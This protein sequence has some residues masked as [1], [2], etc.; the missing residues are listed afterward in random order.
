MNAK[1]GRFLGL[2]IVTAFALTVAITV[3]AGGWGRA[4]PDGANRSKKTLPP[5]PVSVMEA[6][7]ESIEI[8]DSYSGMIRPMERFSLG[9]EIAGRV[10]ALGTIG[11]DDPPGSRPLDQGDRVKAGKVLARL[12]DRVLLARLGEAT[13]RLEEANAQLEKAQADMKRSQGL[14]EIGSRAISEAQYQEDVTKLAVAHAQVAV[15]TAQLQTANKSLQDTTLVSPVDGVISKRMINVGESVTS[16]QAIME[17]LQV[18]EVLLV[19]GVP[20]AYVGEIRVGLPVHV[21]LL[22]RDRFRRR[23]PV[24]EGR[25]YRVAEAADQTTGLFEVEILLDNPQ[26]RWKPGLIALAHIV[27]KEVR[28][29]RVPMISAVFRNDKTFLFS[30]EKDGKPL[31][32]NGQLGTAHRLELEDWIEQGPEIILSE[33]PP[34]H[35]AIVVRGQHRLLDGQHVKVLQLKGDLAGSEGRP[36]QSPTTIVGTGK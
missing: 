9:F 19:V 23:R 24:T 21:E 12:D 7:L 22:A 28:G 3:I 8:T 27:L 17:I 14:K 33:L 11:E 2:I 29:F 32:E 5:T 20:E 15:A 16:H 26:R 18:D 34:Q 10:V 30:A 1:L 13:A 35:R 25:V 6:R 36:V 31:T 4:A